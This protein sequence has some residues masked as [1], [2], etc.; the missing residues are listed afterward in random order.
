[1]GTTTLNSR[2]S[3]LAAAN[4]IFGR[5]DDAKAEE[6]IDFMPTILSRFDTIFIIKDEHNPERDTTLAKHVIGVHMNAGAAASNEVEGELS[7]SFLKKYI[8]FARSRCGP[9][10]SAEAAEKL[11]SK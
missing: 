6:N 7:L 4:S 5:W 11:K 8:N 3:V 2:C 1:M 9:R 10:L